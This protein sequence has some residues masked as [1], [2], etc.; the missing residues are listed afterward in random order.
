[1]GV[2]I[3]NQACI[4]IF[5]IPTCVQ[6]LKCENGFNVDLILSS[7]ATE[8]AIIDKKMRPVMLPAV[9]MKTDQL[10]SGDWKRT[11]YNE[12]PPLTSHLRLF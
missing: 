9:N 3:R 1:M 10:R 6:V 12:F 11:F 8:I 5:T 7:A 4:T 2:T